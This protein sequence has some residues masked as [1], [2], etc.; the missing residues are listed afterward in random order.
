MMASTDD[1]DIV[2][3][4]PGGHGGMPHESAD[5]VVAAA[6][7][8]T[9][10]QS[11]VGRRQDPQRPLVIT[12]GHLEAPGNH[13]VIPARAL[14]Q[15]TVR[16]LDHGSRDDAERWITDAARAAAAPSGAAVD[17][18]YQRGTPPLINDPAAARFLQSAAR[19]HC[20]EVTTT[21]I[22]PVM[23]GEDFSFYLEQ[24]AGA[25]AFVGMGGPGSRHAHHTPCFDIDED[26]LR[27]GIELMVGL[28]DDYGR[29]GP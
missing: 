2:F 11:L 6:R 24:C 22:R 18:T 28:I 19:R 1:F 10:L 17:V 29:E 14:L 3:S 16:A 7:L 25:F 8:V 5:V 12:V 23:G 21:P 15:G 4:G 9:D 26:V 13:N 20:R 27:T